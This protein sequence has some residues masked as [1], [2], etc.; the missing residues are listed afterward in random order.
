MLAEDLFAH[1]KAL[2]KA[3]QFR[4]AEPVYIRLLEHDAGNVECLNLLGLLHADTGR[5][6]TS[7]QLLR[8]AIGIAG[9]EAW[10]CR[11]LGIVLERTGD[12]AGAVAC[13]RQAVECAPKEHE[14]WGA[15]GRLL[16]RLDRTEESMS[17]WLQALA[18]E[19]SPRPR[20]HGRIPA[21]IGE[22]DG[23]PWR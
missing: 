14:I 17:A 10:L 20:C 12:F 9:P 2:H 3:G 1:A 7:I 13:F 21:R 15:L 23:G 5:I 4:E 16:T 11:N 8:V 6:D 22:C 18:G 19:C